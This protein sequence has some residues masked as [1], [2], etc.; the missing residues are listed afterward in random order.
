MSRANRSVQDR[1]IATAILFWV[2]VLPLWWLS[3]AAAAGVSHLLGIVLAI[4]PSA[5]MALGFSR[6]TRAR[7]LSRKPGA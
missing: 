7:A 4:P 2:A 5:C 6:F 1:L 3:F